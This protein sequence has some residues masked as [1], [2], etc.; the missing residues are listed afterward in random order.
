METRLPHTPAGGE[1]GEELR[2]KSLEYLIVTQ[3][4]PVRLHVA[5]GVKAD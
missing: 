4:T 1:G 3:K 2:T 5:S